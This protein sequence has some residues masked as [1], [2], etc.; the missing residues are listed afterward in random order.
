MIKT[1]I[2]DY[3][4]VVKKSQKFSLDIVDLYK[5]S[6]EEY[7]KIIPQLKPIIEKFDRGLIT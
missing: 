4:G 3:D 6:V 5:I 7:E 1:I 2:F